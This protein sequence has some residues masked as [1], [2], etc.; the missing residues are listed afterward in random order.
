MKELVTKEHSKSGKNNAPSVQENYASKEVI[1]ITVPNNAANETQKYMGDHQTEVLIDLRTDQVHTDRVLAQAHM[2]HQA[3]QAHIQVVEAA[4]KNHRGVSPLDAILMKNMQQ[5]APIKPIALDDM[6]T[7]FKLLSNVAAQGL[8][9][10]PMGADIIKAGIMTHSDIEQEIIKIKT[11]MKC[12]AKET[13]E[14][15]AECL[16]V[17]QASIEEIEG[18][19]DSEY[20]EE[21]IEELSARIYS[22]SQ[23]IIKIMH[24]FSLQDTEYRK[25]LKIQP[26]KKVV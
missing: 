4:D 15:I 20:T 19:A 13:A 21:L 16:D 1:Q 3:D 24:D 12:N 2:V 14:K 22:S 18:E 10:L 17:I 5:I 9:H 23:D 25:R 6:P 26:K 8:Y 7:I 11:A